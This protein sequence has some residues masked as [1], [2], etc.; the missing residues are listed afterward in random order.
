MTKSSW[1]ILI[2]QQGYEPTIKQKIEETNI[3]YPIEEVAITIDMPGYVFIRSAEMCQQSVRKFLSL[4]GSIK[5]L[6]SKKNNIFIPEKFNNRDIN[7]LSIHPETIIIKKS[8]CVGDFIIIK[9]GDLADIQGQIIEIK[10]RIVK[11]KPTIFHK[12]VRTRIQDIEPI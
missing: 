11:I 6:G 12:I 8:F 2:V 9:R 1:Y 4:D 3:D 10:K 5:F 7:K